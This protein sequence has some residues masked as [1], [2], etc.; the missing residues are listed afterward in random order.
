[1]RSRSNDMRELLNSLMIVEDQQLREI[2]IGDIPVQGVR[3][4]HNKKVDKKKIE[5]YVT[6]LK[7]AYKKYVSG[8]LKSVDGSFAGKKLNPND[9]EVII[10]FLHASGIDLPIARKIVNHG[11]AESIDSNSIQGILLNEF[12]NNFLNNIFR[13]AATYAVKNGILLGTGKFGKSDDKEKGNLIR[14]PTTKKTGDPGLDKLEAKITNIIKGVSP[15]AA[16]ILDAKLYDGL[17]L[18]TSQIKALVDKNPNN[19]INLL[20]LVG[21]SYLKDKVPTS[22]KSKN[23]INIE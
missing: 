4:W 19:A 10:N 22:S 12:L 7:R 17:D 9:P 15:K 13:T 21:F 20:A 3:N 8:K 16:E 14:P 5:E 2:N 18:T 6:L 23:G 1:M 11:T